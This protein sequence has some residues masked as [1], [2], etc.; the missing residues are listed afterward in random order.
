MTAPS[1]A[2]C[3]SPS[4]AA[5]RAAFLRAAADAGAELS[6]QR[7]PL[8]GPDGAPLFLDAARFGAPD[9]RRVL[10]LASGTHGVE[11]FC[12]SGIQTWLL[13]S[14]LA[15]RLPEGVALVLV[16]AVNPWG[17]AWLRRV[18]EDN[19]DVNRNF[20]DH[21]APHPRNPDYDG[22]YAALNPERLDAE[23]L[24]GCV[25]Q[26]RRFESERGSAASYRALSGGQ[27]RH[28][29][30][31][32]YG[33]QA[34]VWSNRALRS[35]WA[36][37]AA[38]AEVAVF[39]DLHSGLGPRGVGLLLQTAA[40]KSTA[41][42]L[43]RTLWP[44]VIRSEPDAGGASALVSGLIG[45]AFVGAHPEAASLGLVLEFGTREMLQVVL[46]VQADNWLA[47]HGARDSEEGRAISAR[48]RDAFFIEEDD[49]KEKVCQ[50]A[51]EVLDRALSGI[52]TFRPESAAGAPEARVRGAGAGDLDILVAFNLAMA[53][54]TESLA[55]HEPTVR[56]AVAE[57]LEDP[58]RGRWLLVEAGGEIAA[59]LMLTP[60]WSD[61]RGGF[62]WWIQNVYVAPA[63]RRRGHY[64]RL[65]DH[66]RGLAARTPGVCG[67]RL[68]VEHENR[69]AQA[70][71]RALGMQET[72]YK[73]F[74]QLTRPAPWAA[75]D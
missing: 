10:L 19:V 22:L 44:D 2:E 38:G 8:P 74:E 58:A 11:G 21:A 55:L 20:L 60:E 14:G 51:R 70:T 52:A 15:A 56:A 65:H 73:L 64:R 43:G 34:P 12:G 17:F 54:E 31:V 36:R 32:Q 40:E 23:T 72:H 24:K 37:H 3:F 66:V 75:A 7:H 49:W 62:L 68:Y 5:A 13:R 48:M 4:Y 27:Y 16:H 53:R 46:A 45:P 47:Q 26:L 50:R 9:A 29:R 42:A 6:S 71:Y 35:L 63:H 28:P 18:N 25:E 67:L 57:L 59:A 30:G 39:L 69:A 61:W 33:G 1:P 41:A